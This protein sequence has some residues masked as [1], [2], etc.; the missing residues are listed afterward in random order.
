MGLGQGELSVTG[1][2]GSCFQK[3]LHYFAQEATAVFESKVQE[4]Q[5]LKGEL[6]MVTAKVVPLQEAL[7]GAGAQHAA[8]MGYLVDQLQQANDKASRYAEELKKAKAEASRSAEELQK[9][10]AEASRYAEELQKANAEVSRSAGPSGSRGQGAGHHLHAPPPVDWIAARE[11]Q[12]VERVLQQW[13]QRH[14][15]ARPLLVW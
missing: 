11:Q 4:L 7:V 8:D 2:E 12:I 3:L 9:V 14:E 1:D 5:A 15:G 6:H 10:K 13:R